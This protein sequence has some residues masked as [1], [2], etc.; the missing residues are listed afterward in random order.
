MFSDHSVDFCHSQGQNY[1]LVRALSVILMPRTLFIHNPKSVL[2]F[3]WASP[4]VG[5]RRN[6]CVSYMTTVENL[7]SRCKLVGKR[8]AR[9]HRESPK[10]AMANS[11]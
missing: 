5:V 1:G 9:N 2:K 6:G 4:K 7:T 8:V 10:S 3:S 11:V